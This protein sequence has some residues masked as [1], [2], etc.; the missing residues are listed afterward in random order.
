MLPVTVELDGQL[1]EIEAG[2]G[3]RATGA[4]RMPCVFA[5]GGRTSTA[6]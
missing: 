5:G 2:G 3:I 6:S 4:V 1:D